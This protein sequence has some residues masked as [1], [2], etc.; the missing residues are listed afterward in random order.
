MAFERVPCVAAVP[1]LIRRNWRFRRKSG[2]GKIHLCIVF[3]VG[4]LAFTA[5]IFALADD[6]PPAKP[7]ITGGVVASGTIQPRPDQNTANQFVITVTGAREAGTSVWV[8]AVQMIPEGDD[9]WSTQ[10]I[11]Q[12]GSNTLEVWLVDLAGNQGVSEWVDV[13]ISVED[14]V[15]FHYNAEGRLK[16]VW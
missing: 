16:S 7:T 12:P 13:H 1:R 8:N 14:A 10:V 9:D 15:R 11:L 3:L 5:P 6:T 4:M 2:K